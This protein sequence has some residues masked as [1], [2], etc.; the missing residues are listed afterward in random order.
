MTGW[1]KSLR[2][3]MAIIQCNLPCGHMAALPW[4]CSGDQ[5]LVDGRHSDN[6]LQMIFPWTIPFL[7]LLS[8]FYPMFTCVSY[9]PASP[10]RA[11]IYILSRWVDPTP[12]CTTPDW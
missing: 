7:P 5:Q 9:L 11:Y 6:V 8:H 2:R 1:K 10:Y 12:H 4:L 3:R